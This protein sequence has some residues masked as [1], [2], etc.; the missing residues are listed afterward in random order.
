MKKKEVVEASFSDSLKDLG[1]ELL[2]TLKTS[3]IVLGVI[4]VVGLLIYFGYKVLSVDGLS[5]LLG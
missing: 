3:F 5:N 4:I 1:K 2:R